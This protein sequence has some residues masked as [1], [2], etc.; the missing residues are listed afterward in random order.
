MHIVIWFYQITD[1]FRQQKKIQLAISTFEKYVDV[2]ALDEK[3][4]TFIP[5]GIT[6]HMFSTNLAK[7]CKTIS[8]AHRL[9]EGNDDRVLKPL[10]VWCSRK[11]V[12]ITLW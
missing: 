9:P 6:P 8:E 11:F 4:I 5:E 1:I 7:R 2:N 3:I 12:E 10:Q